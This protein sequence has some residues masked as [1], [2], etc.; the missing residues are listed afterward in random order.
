MMTQ[1]T[2]T[3]AL[4]GKTA[5]VT[6]GSRGLGRGIVQSFAEAGAKVIAVA[7]NRDQL[8]ALADSTPNV[9]GVAG[10]ITDE[11]LAGTLLEDENPDIVVLNAGATP[12]LRPF[13]L[14]S[15]STFS[16]NWEVDVKSTFIWLRDALLLPLSAGSQIVVVSSGA[17]LQGSPVSGGYAG[18][19]R[20]QGF[21]A[22]YAADE[23]ARR[24]LDLRIWCLYPQLNPNTE[25]GRAGVAAYARRNGVSFDEFAQNFNPSL[26]PEVMGQGV[27]ALV[28]GQHDSDGTSE[29]LITGKG[30]QALG[31]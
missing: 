22:A 3:T 2:N 18:A 13:H 8:Q 9:R 16:K 21:L 19:K 30:L 31:K 28:T 5:I 17:G 23:S 29:Y 12:M 25:L 26:S 1:V 11:H 6:G 7:R 10:D 24:Q 15:W 14:Q 27:L 4:N 20:T